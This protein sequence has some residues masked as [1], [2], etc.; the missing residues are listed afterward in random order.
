M[1]FRYL[2]HK[3][4]YSAEM[5]KTEDRL[6]VE[7]MQFLFKQIEDFRDEIEYEANSEES[8]L[9]ERLEAD[10]GAKAINELLAVLD[11]YISGE[12]VSTLDSYELGE[13]E[14]VLKGDVECRSE[15]D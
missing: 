15:E 14:A 9:S 1:N 2:I 10:Y 7:G 5:L 4:T 6:F 12:I 11:V 13:E 3:G 8:S